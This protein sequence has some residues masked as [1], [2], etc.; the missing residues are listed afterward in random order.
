MDGHNAEHI[1][2]ALLFH[3]ELDAFLRR[4][5]NNIIVHFFQLHMYT[6]DTGNF[7]HTSPI[8]CLICLGIV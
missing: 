3:P 8:Q 2:V 7:F 4:H 1:S 6:V 5:V